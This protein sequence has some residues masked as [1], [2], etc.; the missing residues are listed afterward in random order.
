V[1]RNPSHVPKRTAYVAHG[2]S[3]AE[4]SAYRRVQPRTSWLKLGIRCAD[5]RWLGL[6]ALAGSHFLLDTATVSVLSHYRGIPAI[7]PW[8]APLLP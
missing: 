1:V 7:R 3:Q 2:R 8:N 5:T 4:T 6:P